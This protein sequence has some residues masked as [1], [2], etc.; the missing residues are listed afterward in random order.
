MFVQPTPGRKQDMPLRAKTIDIVPADARDASSLAALHAAALPPGWPAGTFE[1]YCGASNCAVLKA[2]HGTEICGLAVL[3]FAADEAE[4]L[5]IAVREDK[6][7]LGAGSSLLREALDMC[8]EKNIRSVYLEVGEE[9]ASARRLYG[10]LG[11]RTFGRRVNYYRSS[12][13][14]PEAA[15]IMK[16]DFGE[17]SN[18][19]L[20]S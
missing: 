3:Q 4:L 7:G 10:K 16:F 14:Q 9:N 17:P 11:F 2:V 5:G 1:T 13:P 18:S 12:G 20:D 19:S 15:L 6:R 8:R